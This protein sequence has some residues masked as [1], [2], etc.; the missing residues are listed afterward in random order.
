MAST[1]KPQDSTV[2][3]NKENFS[4]PS[5]VTGEGFSTNISHSKTAFHARGSI[6]ILSTEALNRQKDDMQSILDIFQL[7]GE[8]PDGLG[9][10]EPDEGD[11]AQPANLEDRRQRTDLLRGIYPVLDGLW[12]TGSEYITGA[13]K[14]LADGSRDRKLILILCHILNIHDSNTLV[15]G[16]ISVLSSASAHL[17]LYFYSSLQKLHSPSRVSKA[18]F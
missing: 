12:S 14:Q 3:E 9:G 13:A 5:E 18:K 10:N 6:S 8:L 15:L 2:E 4:L 11:E 1:S 16:V 17:S 7:D